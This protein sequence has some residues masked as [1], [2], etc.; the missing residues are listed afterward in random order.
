[1]R[2]SLAHVAK[3]MVLGTASLVSLVVLVALVFY[4][5]IGEW[6]LPQA[7]IVDARPADAASD[8][9]FRSDDHA[10]D[11]RLGFEEEF[12]DLDTECR[13]QVRQAAIDAFRAAHPN[14]TIDGINAIQV[15]EGSPVW[16]VAI[17]WSNDT[18]TDATPQTVPAEYVVRLFITK[19]G[20]EYWQA[21]PSAPQMTELLKFLAK[22]SPVFDDFE[23][24]P[25]P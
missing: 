10:F 4:D 6:L 2:I 15:G 3:E 12:C 7:P 11:G 5:T 21:T 23:D 25:D 8:P 20:D 13:R 24:G 16:L 19:E 18:T 1:M 17:D 9:S 14:T 22:P